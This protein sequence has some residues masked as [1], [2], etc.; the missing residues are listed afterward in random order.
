MTLVVPC[1][2]KER[3]LPYLANTLR[4]VESSLGGEYPLDLI[5]VD[6]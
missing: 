4:G 3:S 6:G 5:F 1:Y 2:N